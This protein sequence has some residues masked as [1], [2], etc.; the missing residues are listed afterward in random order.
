MSSRFSLRQLARRR[1]E[2]DVDNEAQNRRSDSTLAEETPE[3]GL[4]L[5]NKDAS[6]QAK[7][8]VDI[9]AVHGL[10]G[11]PFK[12]WTDKSGKLWL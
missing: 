12:T 2:K 4:F 11:G 3:L 1:R 7:Y 10:G 5:L 9:V 6:S 8:D